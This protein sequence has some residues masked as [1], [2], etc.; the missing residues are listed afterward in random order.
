MADAPSNS[1]WKAAVGR[2][3][4]AS[5][6]AATTTATTA[7][8]TASKK[9]VDDD[10]DW[11]TDPD[12]VNDVSEKAS[13]WGSKSVPETM[14]KSEGDDPADL[15]AIRDAVRAQHDAKVVAEYKKEGGFSRG[16]GGA[17]GVEKKK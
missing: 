1:A 9:V 2:S 14:A 13:R 7:A 4:A 12:F 10:D 17:Y 11:E 15:A 16:Y 5:A 3:S 8:T 6:T